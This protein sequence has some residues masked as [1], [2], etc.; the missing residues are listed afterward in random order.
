MPTSQDVSKLEGAHAEGIA[1]DLHSLQGLCRTPG[2]GIPRFTA[3]GSTGPGNMLQEGPPPPAQG[4]VNY[5]ACTAR[6]AW[7]GRGPALRGADHQ[8]SC[9]QPSWGAQGATTPAQ[10]LMIWNLMT[11][12]SY[13]S[14]AESRKV[15]LQ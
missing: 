1:E 9:H 11:I 3:A 4:Y 15:R 13:H 10:G 8:A 2:L 6:C 14:R 12:Q 5:S 7:N